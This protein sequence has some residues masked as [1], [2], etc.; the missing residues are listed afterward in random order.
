MDAEKTKFAA[1]DFAVMTYMSREFVFLPVEQNELNTLATGYNSIHFGLFGICFGSLLTL[2]I[3]AGTV[4]LSQYA[5]NGFLSASIVFLLASIYFGAMAR[6]DY[7]DSKDLLARIMKSQ[8][9]PT[10]IVVK[11]EGQP[12]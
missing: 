9:T 2:A 8:S 10:A 3:T 5:K 7:R 12:S 6:K 1:T 4:S 11:P